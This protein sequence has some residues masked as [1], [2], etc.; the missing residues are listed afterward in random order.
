[1]T[2]TIEEKAQLVA[3]ALTALVEL[4]KHKDVCG[5]D[6]YYKKHVDAVWSNANYAL[7]AWERE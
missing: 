6:D 1:M 2:D 4:K 7:A 3:D 5:K